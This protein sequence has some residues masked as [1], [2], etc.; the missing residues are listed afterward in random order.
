MPVR[1]ED[2]LHVADPIQPEVTVEAVLQKFLA[3]PTLLAIAIVLDH[4]PIGIVTRLQITEIMASPNGRDLLGRRPI[5]QTM[6]TDTAF[7]EAGTPVALVAKQAAETGSKILSDGLVV[8][9]DGAY[10]GIVTPAE[11]LKTVATEN[12]ARARAMQKTN[13]RIA[14]T[15]RGVEEMAQEKSRFLA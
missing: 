8:R 14:A 4:M 5:T 11:I 1:I 3:D 13:K 6:A 15:R 7:A 2:I 12:T 10:V 9:R